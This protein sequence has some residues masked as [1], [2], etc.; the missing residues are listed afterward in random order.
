MVEPLAKGLALQQLGD[1]VRDGSIEAD[2][3]DRHDVGVIERCRRPR[4]AAESL[5]VLRPGQGGMEHLD[6]H[7]AAK[8]LIARSI[9]DAHTSGADR[10]HD[11]VGAQPFAG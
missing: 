11:L 10:P 4:F 8:P 3:E 7:I 5:E 9:H 6:R 1:H 2:V